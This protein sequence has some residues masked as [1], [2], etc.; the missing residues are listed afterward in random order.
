M[1]PDALE[2]AMTSL[3]LKLEHEAKLASTMAGA[4]TVSPC[5]WP[6]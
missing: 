5:V 3:M 2:S 4:V 1:L 6:G